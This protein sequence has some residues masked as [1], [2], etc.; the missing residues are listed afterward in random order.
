MLFRDP[1]IYE[2]AH[3]MAAGYHWQAFRRRQG[4]RHLVG[5]VSQLLQAVFS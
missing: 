3:R 2:D 1:T 4:W 5:A